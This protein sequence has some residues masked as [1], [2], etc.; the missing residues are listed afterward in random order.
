MGALQG[1]AVEVAR[2]GHTSA[3]SGVG[4]RPKICSC[5]TWWQ[6]SRPKY[7]F[8]LCEHSFGTCCVT[9]AEAQARTVR[10]FRC[11]AVEAAKEIFYVLSTVPTA[12]AANSALGDPAGI[13]EGL[14]TRLV[15]CAP[16]FGALVHNAPLSAL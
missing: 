5:S 14:A 10:L 7:I 15:E 3:P 8:F 4:A 1:H 6:H 9:P 12:Q 2:S 11:T 16:I 13:A